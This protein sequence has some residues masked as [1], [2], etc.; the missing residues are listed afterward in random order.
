MTLKIAIFGAGSIGC[1]LGGQ[2]AH[3]GLNVT[4]IGRPRFQKALGENGL[5]LTHWA[6]KEI[7]I[8]KESVQF[9]TTADGVKDADII[10]VTVKS[11]DSVQAGAA[12]SMYA[13]AGAIIISFQNGVGN[14]EALEQSLEDFTVLGAVVPFNVTG[15]EPGHFHC[16]TEGNL[17]IKHIED[18][19]LMTLQTSFETSGQGCDLVGDILAVQWGKLLVNLNNGL[20]TLH[21]GPL[22]T[23]LI[24]AD[25]RKA[26]ALSL[27]EGLKIVKALGVTPANFGKASPSKMIKM[28]RLPNILYKPLMDTVVKIDATARSS[29]LDD[30][31]TGRPTEIDYLQG[32]VVDLA[33]SLDMEAPVNA[34]V[35]KAVKRAFAEGVSPKMTGTEILGV[36]RDCK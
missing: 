17:T 19:R 9:E 18:A 23:G 26:L 35:M 11:Q 3:A 29:M 13:K 20:N 7:H 28:L 21:G 36:I 14:V 5:T 32:A 22:K 33:K 4:F 34:G 15:T 30:L 1:Y 25:Y 27:E 10:L 2:L 12:I 24:Q 31:E 6:R 16:G 8:D